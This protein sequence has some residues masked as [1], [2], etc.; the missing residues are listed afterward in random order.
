[1][2]ILHYQHKEI[3]M[4]KQD[5]LVGTVIYFAIKRQLFIGA[6]DIIVAIKSKKIVRVTKGGKFRL[7]SGELVS[8]EQLSKSY[9]LDLDKLTEELENKERADRIKRIIEN[10][11]K[12]E[13]KLYTSLNHSE[14][15]E[16]EDSLKLL[17]D[18]MC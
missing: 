5:L 16:L 4:K 17:K 6:K 18:K 11:F 7:C 9:T 8:F 14:L 3:K 13:Y 2:V 12:K 1:M 10:A 15:L